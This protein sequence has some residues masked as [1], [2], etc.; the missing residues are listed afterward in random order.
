[1]S[2]EPPAP[3]R[4]R[5]RYVLAALLPLFVAIP[6]GFL[7][8][9][10][11]VHAALLARGLEPW[12]LE[13]EALLAEFGPLELSLGGLGNQLVFLTLSAPAL[14]H[15][16]RRARLFGQRSPPA[17]W[18]L[19]A[20]GMYSL[21]VFLSV[22]VV[23]LGFEGQGTLGQFNDVIARLGILGRL[24]LLPVLALVAGVAEELF[25]RGLLFR[26]LES[27]APAR[28]VVVLTALAFGLAHLDPVHSSAAFLMG[29]YLG[30]LRL[31]TGSVWPGIVAHVFSNGTVVLS[32]GWLDDLR[33]VPGFG[34]LGSGLVFALA[35]WAL[36]RRWR[37]PLTEE[38]TP[39]PRSSADPS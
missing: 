23:S 27:V 20:V 37:G 36:S 34:L 12:N 3:Q 17:T 24:Q 30:W 32:H 38:C 39:P 5:G 35:A 21:S 29:L 6:L 25:F 4:T 10:L 1:M 8:S 15:P 16:E 28:S 19:G 13:P 7:V 22:L 11:L 31:R 2:L 14:L 18:A 33:D 9:V 26:R